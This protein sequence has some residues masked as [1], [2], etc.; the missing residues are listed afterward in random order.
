MR[1]FFVLILFTFSL[2]TSAFAAEQPRTTSLGTGLPTTTSKY[3]R[4]DLPLTPNIE[5]ENTISNEN[6]PPISKTNSMTTL[7]QT[8]STYYIFST[9]GL[10]LVAL[11]TLF[12]VKRKR[13]NE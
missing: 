12:I 8:S 5:S 13:G 4:K 2:S 3:E 7:P 9:I 6:I 1:L 10:I 11:S